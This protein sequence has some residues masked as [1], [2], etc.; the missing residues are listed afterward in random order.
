MLFR[1]DFA[2]NPL[3]FYGGLLALLFGGGMLLSGGGGND[4]QP[5]VVNNYYGTPQQPAGYNRIPYM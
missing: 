2:K 3:G 1:S 4:S 5:Q